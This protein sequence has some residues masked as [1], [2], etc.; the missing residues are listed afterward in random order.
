MKKPHVTWTF[1]SG[2]KLTFR[3]DG[4]HDPIVS[5]DEHGRSIHELSAPTDGETDEA[6][7]GGAQEDRRPRSRR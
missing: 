4:A 3:G 7:N 2:A 1:V 5:F 6:D